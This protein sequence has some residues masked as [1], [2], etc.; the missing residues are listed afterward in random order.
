M[1]VHGSAVEGMLHGCPCSALKV[2]CMAVHVVLLKVCCMAVH[3]LLAI[4]I[5]FCYNMLN[6]IF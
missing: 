5:R 3:V 4:P 6:W 2:C 1:A